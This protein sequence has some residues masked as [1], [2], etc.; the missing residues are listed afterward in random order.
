M[1]RKRIILILIF[2]LIGFGLIFYFKPLDKSVSVDK[3]VVIKHKRSL[4]LISNN[5]IIKSYK[6]SLGRVLK[7]IK[8]MKEIK[9]LPK[10][11]ISSIK[12]SK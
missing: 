4:D 7:G 6:I 5:Q 11:Y 9:R 12:K 2:G 10:D 1:K 8:N 3:I